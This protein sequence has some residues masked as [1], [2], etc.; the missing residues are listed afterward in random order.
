MS[1]GPPLKRIFGVVGLLASLLGSSALFSGCGS[2]DEARPAQWSYIYPAIIE[3]SCA[4]ASCHSDF[5]QR[6]G[7][8]FGAIDT[9]YYQMVCR[10]FVVQCASAGTMATNCGAGIPS[11][12]INDPACMARAVNDS[13]VIHMMRAE[14]A[15]RMPPDYALPDVDIRLISEWISLGAKND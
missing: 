7:V 10:H 11:P 9:A 1:L 6:S 4:T 14:G 3:P 5:T 15:R 8:N 2:P 13:Q 12:T